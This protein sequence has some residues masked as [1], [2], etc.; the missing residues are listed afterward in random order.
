M[1]GGAAGSGGPAV[2]SPAPGPTAP[3]SLLAGIDPTRQDDPAYRQA[4]R[5]CL[6]R[7]GF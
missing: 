2:G 7:R 3:G 6:Q 1:S 4:Y 5:D